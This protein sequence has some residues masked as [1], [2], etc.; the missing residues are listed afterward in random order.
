[1]VVLKQNKKYQ[2]VCIFFDNL[3]I[4]ETV[5]LFTVSLMLKIS[6]AVFMKNAQNG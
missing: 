1:M 4:I 5:G 6:I 3:K 2:D